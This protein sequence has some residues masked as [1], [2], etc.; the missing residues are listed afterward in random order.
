MAQAVDE[1]KEHVFRAYNIMAGALDSI[2]E[3]SEVEGASVEDLREGI[4]AVANHARNLL[5]L[6]RGETPHPEVSG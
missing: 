4:E 3:M 6:K 5:G 1:L 2:Q